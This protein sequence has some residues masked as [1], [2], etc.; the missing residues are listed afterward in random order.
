MSPATPRAVV[1]LSDDQLFRV[2]GRDPTK[3]AQIGALFLQ[4]YDRLF[5]ELVD[6]IVANQVPDIQRSLHS[7]KGMAALIGA[8]AAI[9][10]TDK[11]ENL[12]EATLSTATPLPAAT[13]NEAVGNLKAAL[14]PYRSWFARWPQPASTPPYKP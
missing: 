12:V 2:F 13:L 14:L 3:L 8:D 7:I 9:D 4:Q 6:A 1:A 5:E 11:L 10:D